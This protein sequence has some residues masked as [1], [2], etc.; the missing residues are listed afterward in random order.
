MERL[1]LRPMTAAE[2]KIYRARLIPAY[3][4]ENVQA[5]D[6]DPDQAE[7]LAAR[8]TDDL[9]PAGPQTPGMLVLAAENGNGE[10]VGQVWIALS[11]PGPGSAWIYDIEISPGHR[12]RGYGRALLQAA[13]E[14]ARQHGAS[15]IGLNVFGANTVARNLYE[16]SGYQATSL[17]M[18]KPLG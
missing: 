13:E 8:E 4:A 3:A 18:R 17:V 12:G 1:R 2:F 6:W 15:A 10:Q 9:L 5:G 11:R 7:T 16:S 14:R